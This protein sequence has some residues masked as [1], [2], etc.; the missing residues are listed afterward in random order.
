[1]KSQLGIIIKFL[2]SINFTLLAVLS[3]T[4]FPQNLNLLTTN[5]PKVQ[6]VIIKVPPETPSSTGKAISQAN[7]N[8]LGSKAR[9]KKPQKQ[10]KMYTGRSCLAI[11]LNTLAKNDAVETKAQMRI[12]FLQFLYFY[13]IP[14][15]INAPNK[16]ATT[17]KASKIPAQDYKESKYLRNYGNLALK[18]M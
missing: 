17:D 8:K 10:P 3:Q 12:T 9:V 13:V 14:P 15:I 1:M 18:F 11:Q 16:P 7:S 4:L 6:L 2:L 5:K